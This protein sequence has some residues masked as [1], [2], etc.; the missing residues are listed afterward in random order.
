[1]NATLETSRESETL[2][3][4]T[5]TLSFFQE[6]DKPKAKETQRLVKISSKTTTDKESGKKIPPAF[7]PFFLILPEIFCSEINNLPEV[8]RE[9]VFS[10]CET[11]L[12]ELAANRKKAG[13]ESLQI[14]TSPTK[15]L[16][17]A[18]EGQKFTIQNIQ[19][20]FDSAVSETFSS[21]RDEARRE[22]FLKTYKLAFCKLP[23]GQLQEA[24]L[25]KLADRLS[26]LSEEAQE[27]PF[28]GK[29]LA[30]IDELLSAGDMLADLLADEEEEEEASES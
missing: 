26:K 21:I 27:L 12:K 5:I 30:R 29:V 11:L 16:Q 25:E 10:A 19:T 22:K 2:S 4:S 13:F 18:G 1:M 3:F 7:S 6:S 24:D 17:E 20:W 28:T 8:F 14:Q 23:S 15:L 9:P